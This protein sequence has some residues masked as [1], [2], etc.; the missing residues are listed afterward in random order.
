MGRPLAIAVIVVWCAWASA[1]AQSTFVSLLS[2][3]ETSSQSSDLS[4]LADKP[5][6]RLREELAVEILLMVVGKHAYFR[7]EQP[8]YEPR[9][10]QK[11][12][13]Q[14]VF[15]MA[16]AELLQRLHTMEEMDEKL[17][18]ALDDVVSTVR[19]LTVAVDVFFEVLA[20]KMEHDAN[21]QQDFMK[22]KT[23]LERSFDLLPNTRIRYSAPE[24]PT[25]RTL[26]L[27]TAP[28]YVELRKVAICS[29][30]L[31]TRREP[32]SEH[33]KYAVELLKMA[34]TESS[35]EDVE[36]VFKRA[37]EE[38]AEEFVYL[39][40]TGRVLQTLFQKLAN[41]IKTGPNLNSESLK[42]RSLGF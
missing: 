30:F 5:K 31:E 20:R 21:L 18:S 16:A 22:A 10:E 24:S 36:R 40:D 4:G 3:P 38:T 9:D 11:D 23:T 8:D 28:Q 1:A 25:V 6:V 27:Q 13:Q 35:R 39:R 32:E 12:K 34:N 15:A 41:S 19:N 2:P 26:I 29:L 17:T 42:A 33:W 37:V 7:D 14:H